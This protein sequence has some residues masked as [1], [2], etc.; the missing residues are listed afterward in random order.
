MTGWFGAACRRRRKH[1]GLQH[2]PAWLTAPAAG[3]CGGR[4]CPARLPC[5]STPASSCAPPGV[6]RDRAAGSRRTRSRPPDCCCARGLGA[7]AA[8]P[9]R[10]AGLVAWYAW[11]AWY[12]DTVA[13][14]QHQRYHDRTGFVAHRGQVVFLFLILAHGAHS[15][16]ENVTRLYE[17]FAPALFASSLAA[18]ILSWGS[19]SSTRLLS[20]SVCGAG[21]FPCAQAGVQLAG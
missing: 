7:F 1:A 15:I 12:A 2:M 8:S 17:V 20:R 11:Y 19:W 6:R 21:P 3:G 10:L 13:P 9:A 14:R 16:K 5:A 4:L 18:T